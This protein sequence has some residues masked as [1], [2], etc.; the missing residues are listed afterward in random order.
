MC[1]INGLFAAGSGRNDLPRVQAM[2]ARLKHRG[3]DDSGTWQHGALTLGHVRLSIIDLSAAGHQPMCSADGRYALVFNGE[4]YNFRDIRKKIDREHPGIIYKSETDSEVLLYACILYGTE[5][6][7]LLNGMFAFAF[8]DTL[9]GELLLVRDRLGIKPLYYFSDGK[10][11]VFS[12]EI[13]ALLA[14]GIPEKKLNHK[15]LSDYFRYN[16]VHAP[17]TLVQGVQLLLPGHYMHV[18]PNLQTTQ[19]CYWDAGTNASKHASVKREEAVEQVKHLLGEAVKRRLVADVPFGA[20]LS[21]GIDSSAIVA[22]MSNSSS[23]PVSTFSVTFDDAAFSEAKYS[24]MIADKYGTRHTEIRLRPDDFLQDL[25]DAMNA[26]DHPGNDGPNTFVVSRATRKAGITMALSGLG[27]DE[28]FAGYPVFT[29]ALTFSRLQWLNAL[30]AGLRKA[31]ASTLHSFANKPALNKLAELLSQEE[32]HFP[33]FYAGSRKLFNEEFLQTLTRGVFP[34]ENVVEDIARRAQAHFPDKGHILSRVS[35]AEMYSYMQHVL[36]RDTDQMSMAVALEVRVPFLDYTLVEYVMGLSDDIKYPSS[37]KKLLVDAL[38][39]MLPHELV[40]RPKMGFT[41]PWKHWLKNELHTLTVEQLTALSKR[42]F[43]D[44]K[45]IQGLMDDF[46]QDKP[47][48]TWSR[49]WHLVALNHWMETN[50]ISE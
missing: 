28:L 29:R 33:A 8:Y 39:D 50:G 1:G 9:T 2:N 18:S 35:Y 16:T 38:G 37:P 14:S 6:I 43:A 49:I 45:N 15:A 47:Q 4:I 7:H 30:P 24:R 23:T 40:H 11:L 36:L 27:G 10:H 48:A 42:S 41:L 3:P 5:A 17:Q 22:L 44:V 13:R 32:L 19:T 21:G 12:S 34:A 25:P 20:F 31:I 46:M 26:M